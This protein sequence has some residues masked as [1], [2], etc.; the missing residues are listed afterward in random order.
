MPKICYKAKKFRAPSLDIINKANAIIDEFQGQGFT[1]TLRQ[2]YYQFISRDFLPNTSKSY[3][4]L[5]AIINAARLAGLI[6]WSSIE[7]RTRNLCSLPHWE[8]ASSILQD[9]ATQFQF[10]LWEDQDYYLEVWIEKDAL[11]GVIASICE[12]YDVPYLSC[13]GYT[14]QSEMWAASQRLIDRELAGKNTVI[15][16]LGDHDPSG[17]DMT[18][19]I[20]DRL[21]LFESTVRVERIALTW[22][23][24]EEYSPPPNFAKS[25]DA[26]FTNYEDKYGNESW[27]LDALEPGVIVS[28][29]ESSV[30]YYLD[31][32][33]WEKALAKRDTIRSDLNLIAN[34]YDQVSDFINRRRIRL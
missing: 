33:R 22:D 4:N 25:T 1:L 3:D 6:D 29:V 32:D 2:L 28:L 7:D 19:D 9:T 5:G 34:K 21:A 16:H 24:I 14:S 17:I 11:V 10:D 8:N 18:R 30:E 12:S 13:R 23:Q 20:Q 15:I 31:F 27:E 26:R